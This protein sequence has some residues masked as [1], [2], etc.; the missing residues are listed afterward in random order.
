MTE[1]DRLKWEAR[2]LQSIIDTW[3]LSQKLRARVVDLLAYPTATETHE[4]SKD[5]RTQTTTV[6]PARWNYSSLAKMAELVVE[7]EDH[8]LSSL[9]PAEGDTFDPATATLEEFRAYLGRRH[10]YPR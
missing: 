3:D 8:L 7:M 10:L 5:G 2:R 6:R 4:V 1:A 9:L